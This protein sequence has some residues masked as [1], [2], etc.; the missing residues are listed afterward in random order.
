MGVTFESTNYRFAITRPDI[1]YTLY[2]GEDHL[3]LV[4]REV[5][6]V[7]PRF[8]TAPVPLPRLRLQLS[9]LYTEIY[10]EKYGRDPK[11]TSK[12]VG[13]GLEEDEVVVATVLAGTPYVP[14]WLF[15]DLF[16]G[17]LLNRM[18]EC[19][20]AEAVF[21]MMQFDLRETALR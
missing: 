7:H 17:D 12:C 1:P 13:F 20:D 11:F 5:A 3:L 21:G 10:K 15:S 18:D 4:P 9:P 2:A 6:K 14:Q 16:K 19:S 8:P